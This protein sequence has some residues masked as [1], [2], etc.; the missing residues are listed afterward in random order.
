M[1]EFPWCGEPRGAIELNEVQPPHQQS[2]DGILDAR[3][4]SAIAVANELRP[5]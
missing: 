4:L 3:R 5:A 2:L 1:V